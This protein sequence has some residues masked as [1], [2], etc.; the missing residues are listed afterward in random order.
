MVDEKGNLLDGDELLNYID[1]S[2][3]NRTGPWAG[4]VETKMSKL[5]Y[6]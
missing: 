6:C 5:G 1:F 3:P 2:N 4:V